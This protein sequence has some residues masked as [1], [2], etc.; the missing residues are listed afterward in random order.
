M[1]PGLTSIL[2]T[3][4]VRFFGPH[5]CGIRFGP[6]NVLNTSSRG[7]SQMRV[8]TISCFPGSATRLI[9]VIV[10]SFFRLFE[11]F[12]ELVEGFVPAGLSH[13]AIL[14]RR[15]A[16]MPQGELRLAFM[17]FEHYRHQ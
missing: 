2:S 3:V 7:A 4:I 6:V 1:P 10:I 15:D 11:A 16:D 14:A 9:F 12:G 13:I 5:H 8:M 17:F